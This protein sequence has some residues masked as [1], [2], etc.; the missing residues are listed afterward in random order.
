MFAVIL[1]RIHSGRFGVPFENLELRKHVRTG[2]SS[3]D[4]TKE[5]FGTI[6][7]KQI[8]KLYDIYQATTF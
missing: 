3:E 2:D 5:W 6:T 4:L 7:K 8:R 1:G